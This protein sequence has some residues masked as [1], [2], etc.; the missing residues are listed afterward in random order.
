MSEN[1]IVAGV[2]DLKLVKTF[3]EE[4]SKSGYKGRNGKPDFSFEAIGLREG[5][6][7]YVNGKSEAVGEVAKRPLIIKNNSV[8]LYNLGVY[9]S[10]DVADIEYKRSIGKP[11]KKGNGWITFK[12]KV[13]KDGKEAILPIKKLWLDWPN[14]GENLDFLIEEAN[15]VQ[16]KTKKPTTKSDTAAKL[17]EKDSIIAE[18]EKQIAELSK[19]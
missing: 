15:K 2:V 8:E 18:L 4:W 13:V 12:V 10:L 19:K 9:P 11:I 16:M 5:V 1:N 14:V 7:L 3:V 17:S 6:K